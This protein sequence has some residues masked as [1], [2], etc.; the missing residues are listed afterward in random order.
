MIV[1]QINPVI[2][3]MGLAHFDWCTHIVVDEFNNELNY[4][5]I[6][7]QTGEEYHKPIDMYPCKYTYS[8]GSEI[9]EEEEDDSN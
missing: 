9:V 3:E 5:V 4:N 8:V 7:D 6:Q 1:K 2:D